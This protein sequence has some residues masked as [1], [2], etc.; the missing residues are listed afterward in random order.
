MRNLKLHYCNEQQTKVSHP[1][2]MLQEPEIGLETSYIATESNVYAV[3]ATGDAP[4][5]VIADLPDIVAAEFLQLN[6]VICVATR[7]GEVLL[8]D[9][10]TL[11]TSE[12]TYCDVGIERMAWSPN[13]EVVAFITSSHNV[14]VMNSTF[15]VIAEQPLEAEL[16]VDQQFVNVGWGK[17]ETQF[18]GSAGKQAAKQ[19]TDQPTQDTQDLLNKEVNIA[20]RGDGAYFVVSY[21]SGGRTFKVYDCEGKLQ[22]TAEKSSNLR[23]IIAW[24]PSGN[25][26]ALPQWFPNKSTISLF[27]KNG[28]RHREIVLPFDLQEEQILQLK[29]SED[30]DILAIRTARKQ[31]QQQRVYLYTIGNYH[32]Y[33]KQVL[34]YADT[35]PVAVLHWDTRMGAEQTLHVL[36][37]SG[38]QLVYS[39]AFDVEPSARQGIVGVI[40]GK[41]LL[42]TDFARAVVPPPMSQCVLQLENYINAI[43]WDDQQLCVYT[44]D[45]RFHFYELKDPLLQQPEPRGS[46]D[47]QSTDGQLLQL[48]NFTYFASNGQLLA[49]TGVQGNTRLLWLQKSDDCYTVLTSVSINGLV[50]ALSRATHNI[51]SIYAHTLDSGKTY[52]V[53]LTAENTF[54]VAH[55]KQFESSLQS[56]LVTLRSQQLLQLGGN[57]PQRIAEDV[58]SFLFFG[59]YLAYTQMNSL[60]FVDTENRQHLA[61]RSIERGA[62]LVTAIDEEAR[63]VL[64][65]PRGNLEAIYPRL[66]VL[67]QVKVLLN[68]RRGRYLAAMK[69]LRKHRINLN[70]ICDT[71]VEKFVARVDVFLREIQESQWLCLFISELQDADT[72]AM[73][74]QRSNESPQ[75][76]PPGFKFEQKVAYICGLLSKRMS[77]TPSAKERARFRLPLVT[78]CVRVGDVNAAL[79]LIRQ[80]L[81]HPGQEDQYLK[82][83]MYLVDINELYNVALGSYDLGMALFV[84]QKSQKDPKEFLQYLNELKALPEDYRKFRI[85][86]HLKRYSSA[87][88]HLARCGEEHHEEAMEFTRKHGLYTVALSSYKVHPEFHRRLCVAYA[89]QLRANAKLENASLMYERGGELQQALLSARHTLDWQRVLVLAKAL[90]E[91]PL[92]Q[93]ALSLVGPL[94]QQGRHLEA[95]ELVKQHVRDTEK[96]MEVLLEG[97]LY[98]KAIYEAGLQGGDILA[99]KIAPALVAHAGQMHNSLKSDLQLF[100]EYKQRLLDIRQRR[101]NGAD[102]EGGDGDVDIDEVDLLSDT[103]SMQSSRYSGTSRGTGKTFRSSKNRRKHER[104]LLS[105]KPGNPFEDIALI[106]ALHQHVTKIGQQQQVVRDTCKALLQLGGGEDTLAQALQREFKTLLQTV[107]SALDEIWIPELVGSSSGSLAQHLTGPNVDYMAL[108]KEQRYALISPLKRF[109]PQLNAVDWQHEILQ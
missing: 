19:S 103:S 53:S 15:D 69:L 14:V 91:Q 77:E 65:L 70:I 23:E 10:E 71:N 5:K 80:D 16:P 109:K 21:V 4:L 7:A 26:I 89:D 62:K 92:E 35:D 57:G 90:G 47:L 22:H 64:Q 37:E 41:R 76:L 9:P 29:W 32:W 97:H 104:K 45:Q 106:D 28:L 1:R 25:W 48:S 46:I 78:V 17:K 75:R 58:T 39:W 67:D 102:T 42:L 33:L 105:L 40:D 86:D 88:Q 18:H 44:C 31:E 55:A 101:A 50:K 95:S 6:N 27:E 34:V 87:V 12:G 96:H 99:E 82:Y 84:A 13:Q 93:V 2:Q 60:H 20:W 63:V 30:S 8:I 94:Q 79:K 3:T 74:P 68:D 66:L 59:T 11:A 98:G 54:A 38:K 61:T 100:L 83:L 107:E 85:D 72:T 49:T 73:Y 81:E 52:D 24:R 108:Q 56:G 36:L 43:A 51:R